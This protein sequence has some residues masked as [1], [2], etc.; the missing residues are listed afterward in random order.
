MILATRRR[1]FWLRFPDSSRIF[2]FIE[3]VQ[4]GAAPALA[5]GDLLNPVE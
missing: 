5:A 3:N 1:C 2:R 4:L